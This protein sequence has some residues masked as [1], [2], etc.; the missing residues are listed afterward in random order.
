ML[1][2]LGVAGLLLLLAAIFARKRLR[3][4]G[5]TRTLFWGAVGAKLAGCGVLLWFHL[6]SYGSSDNQ[7]FY[8]ASRTLYQT[9]AND[10][11]LAWRV[12]TYSPSKLHSRN[13][14]LQ[15][16]VAWQYQGLIARP[17]HENLNYWRWVALLYPLG[18]GSYIGLNLWF[19]ALAFAGLWYL[20]RGLQ[21]HLAPRG[22]WLSAGVLFLLPSVSIWSSGLL[23]EALLCAALGL[24]AGGMLRLSHARRFALGALLAVLAGLWGVWSIKMYMFLAVLPGVLAWGLWETWRWQSLPRRGFWPVLAGAL[25]LG[26]WGMHAL[27]FDFSYF[28]GHAKM[29]REYT[30]AFKDYAPGA[31]NTVRFPAY[32]ASPGDFLRVLPLGFLTTYFRPAPWEVGSWQT[33]AMCAENVL[34]AG[35]LLW[36]GLRLP[37]LKRWR[38]PG[39]PV[40]AALWA[41]L[42]F[43]VGYAAFL[44]VSVLFYG[45]LMRY[46]AACLPFLLLPVVAMAFPVPKPTAKS[47]RDTA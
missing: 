26:A 45:T 20:W 41:L 25:L 44:G 15:R 37:R 9:A 33:L 29:V 39:G 36:G 43:A 46:R 3:G 17:G 11:G 22:Q 1:R 10:P 21:P 30:M 14:P 32:E 16:R 31:P 12:I 6:F 47:A 27:G 13:D 4:A 24:L 28:A 42:P 35:L 34:I 7:L 5:R 18:L 23:K 40:P 2:P 19:A 8:R 38:N